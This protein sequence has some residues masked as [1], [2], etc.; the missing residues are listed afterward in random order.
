MTEP[1][2]IRVTAAGE[3]TYPFGCSDSW[4]VQRIIEAKHNERYAAEREKEH[5]HQ[6]QPLPTTRSTYESREHKRL[7][8]KMEATCLVKAYLNQPNWKERVKYL[9]ECGYKY[10]GTDANIIDKLQKKIKSMIQNGD[11]EELCKVVEKE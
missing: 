3:I 4:E 2:T 6:L 9:K 10:S 7:L 8:E 11:W 1:F 5:Q